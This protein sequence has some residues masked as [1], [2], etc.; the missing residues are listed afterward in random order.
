MD[1]NEEV[2]GSSDTTQV[3]NHNDDPMQYSPSDGD[4]PTAMIII[5]AVVGAVVLTA[6]VGVAF[7][8]RHHRRD[9]DRMS[10]CAPGMDSVE[11]IHYWRH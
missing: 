9:L 1:G 8:K 4:T 10:S 5:L 7:I 3:Y 6:I 11:E 2:S